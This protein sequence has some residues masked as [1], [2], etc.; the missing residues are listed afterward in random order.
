MTGFTGITLFDPLHSPAMKVCIF[1]FFSFYLLAA[2]HSMWDPSSR[3]RD[4]THAPGTGSTEILT[5]RPPGKPRR[6]FYYPHFTENEAQGGDV[7]GLRSESPPFKGRDAHLG[8]LG[9]LTA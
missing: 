2:P 3:T 8:A 7:S 4:R 1:Y 6:S 9:E 5:T